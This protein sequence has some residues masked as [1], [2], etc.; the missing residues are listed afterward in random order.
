MGV[1]GTKQWTA[2]RAKG[3]RAGV[4]LAAITVALLLPSTALATAPSAT[5]LPASN[6]TATSALLNGQI[7]AHDKVASWHFD[8]AS[9][10]EFGNNGTYPHSTPGGVAQACFIVCVPLLNQD[11]FVSDGAHNLSP[12]T[13]YHFRVVASNADGTTFGQDLTFKTLR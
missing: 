10:D 11:V 12:K 5:T 6:I 2:L 13:V 1:S 7:N 8:Y 4:P 3:L 9:D